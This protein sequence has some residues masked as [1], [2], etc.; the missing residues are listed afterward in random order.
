MECYTYENGRL[1]KGITSKIFFGKGSFDEIVI[2][3]YNPPEMPG[4]IIYYAHA[5]RN[6]RRTIYLLEKPKWEKE[7]GVIVLIRT[8]EY[9]FQPTTGKW[10]TLKGAPRCLET[11]PDAG[12]MVMMPGDQVVITQQETGGY[13]E[14]RRVRLVY[15]NIPYQGNELC[16]AKS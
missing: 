6:K 13:R 4:E 10:E 16:L 3:H 7:E 9:G 2:N 11:L 15:K 1:T 8:D 5:R 12:I 14:T